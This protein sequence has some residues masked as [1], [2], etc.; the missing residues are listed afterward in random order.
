M[1]LSLKSAK[2]ISFMGLDNA[3]KTS[4]LIALDRKYNFIEEIEKLKPTV[5]VERSSFKFL[6]A[7]IYRHDFGGQ[8]KFREEYLTDKNKY[9]SDTSL[10]FFIMDIQDDNRFNESLEYFEQIA[11]YFKEIGQ[12][13]PILIMLHKYDPKLKEDK[14]LIRRIRDLKKEFFGWLPYNDIYFFESS[15][16][17][18]YS[19]INA[20][21]FG[22]SQIFPKK[23]LIDKYIES[24]GKEFNTTA[25]LLFSE[26][27]VAMSEYYKR[28]LNDN[29]KENVKTQFFNVKRRISENSDNVYEFS[30]WISAKTRVSGVIQSF[31]IGF[32]KFFVLFIIRESTE[33]DA[34][35]LLDKIGSIK[36]DLA[37]ILESLI[38][39]ASVTI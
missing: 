31:S 21:S 17:E 34:V 18:I 28:F 10:L 4:I 9:L 35:N 6:D 8:T 16:Y 3:G 12:K 1:G 36:E 39:N 26:D 19:L 29:E 7:S 22:L 24:V 14:D 5:K 30:N 13:I 37:D 25:L 33:K 20:F 27:G 11:G 2:K 15:I 38:S 23:E 32:L